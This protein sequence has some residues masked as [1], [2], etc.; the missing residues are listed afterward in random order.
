MYGVLP[1]LPSLPF[2]LTHKGSFTFSS[3]RHKSD[4][5]PLDLN[6]LVDTGMVF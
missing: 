3:S 6:F 1:A 4:V 5:L 2:W